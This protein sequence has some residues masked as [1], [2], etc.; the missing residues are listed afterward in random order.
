MTWRFIDRE[1]REGWIGEG[2]SV[3]Y[4]GE[5]EVEELVERYAAEVD[6][7]PHPTADPTQQV[8]ID[9]Y[10]ASSIRMIE[11]CAAASVGVDG[12]SPADRSAHANVER[13]T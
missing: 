10:A 11:R 4:S 13:S 9:L 1:G 2:L 8:V 12:E 6:S 3:H 7:D 5:E